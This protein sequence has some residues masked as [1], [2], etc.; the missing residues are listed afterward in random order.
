MS[1]ISDKPNNKYKSKE[2]INK[3]KE[4]KQDK[5]KSA[6]NVNK[7][8]KP[9]KERIIPE[10]DLSKV[11]SDDEIS[12]LSDDGDLSGDDFEDDDFKEK[13]KPDEWEDIYGRKRDKE[14]NII[15]VCLDL[16]KIP[17]NN[18][19]LVLEETPVSCRG[20]LMVVIL[21]AS[22]TGL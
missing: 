1:C 9:S 14:G 19:I 3:S 17:I 11:F 8:N 22:Q 15:K 2:D 16:R 7:Q 18:L 10:D 12:H 20:L 4:S 21:T 5:K 6:L 13:D